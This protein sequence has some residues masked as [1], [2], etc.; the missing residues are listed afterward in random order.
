MIG[1]G[2]GKGLEGR[3]M[4]R[5]GEGRGLGRRRGQRRGRLT[6]REEWKE[7]GG[8]WMFVAE[9]KGRWGGEEWA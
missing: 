9:G 4:G 5:V 6:G 7:A 2:G 8:D 3:G 1:D